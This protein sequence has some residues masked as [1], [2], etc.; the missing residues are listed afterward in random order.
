MLGAGKRCFPQAYPR[1]FPSAQ[2]F[3]ALRHETL[4][5]KVSAKKIAVR[6]F[7]QARGR[8]EQRPRCAALS[9]QSDAE[10]VELVAASECAMKG[11]L[12]V[13]ASAAWMLCAS[14]PLGP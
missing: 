5:L 10:R 13:S 1:A 2:K 9:P 3:R 12:E 7:L 8:K 6:K 4:R 11:T 14:W